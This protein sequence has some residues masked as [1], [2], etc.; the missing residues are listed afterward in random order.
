[1]EQNGMERNG[2][3]QTERNEVR[4][5]RTERNGAV[6]DREPCIEREDSASFRIATLHTAGTAGGHT[7]NRVEAARAKGQG[8]CVN[9]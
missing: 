8:S 6:K 5:N 3:R 2:S 4:Q 9:R 1:M 7:E